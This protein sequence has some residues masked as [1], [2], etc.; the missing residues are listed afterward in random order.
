M[1][2]MRSRTPFRRRAPSWPIAGLALIAIV[3]FAAPAAA[4]SA[5]E[6]HA[7]ALSKAAKHEFAAGRYE[8][9]ARHFMD[10]Y[11][12]VPEPTLV[13]NAARAYQKGGKPSE[14]LPLFRLYLSIASPS[15][16]GRAEAQTHISA[17]E[18]TLRAQ[19]AKDAKERAELERKAREA[20]KPVP[21]APPK[22]VAV[23][24]SVVTPTGRA[25]VHR[26]DLFE[27]LQPGNWTG[28]QK[29]G[30]AIMA[31]G[32]ALFITGVIMHVMQTDLEAID[33]RTESTSS[34]VAGKKTYPGVTQKEAESALDSHNASAVT[35]NVLITVGV[36]AGGI[37]TWLLVAPESSTAL[38]PAVTR[39]GGMLVLSGRF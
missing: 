34:T 32:G 30:V 39:D 10:A 9:A 21:V 18:A 36:I 25:V 6:K 19:D 12:K 5:D 24:P 22:P 3:H 14:A 13:Y 17:I 11:A 33:S 35:A 26:P 29:T 4:T 23:K 7:V 28:R 8:Q 38:A 20:G 15:D 37:G 16:P 2:T 31:G 1:A 27:R